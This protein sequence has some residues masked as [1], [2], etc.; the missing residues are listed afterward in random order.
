MRPKVYENHLRNS[1]NEVE[2]EKQTLI[3]IKYILYIAFLLIAAASFGQGDQE[4]KEAKWNTERKKLKYKKEA[5]YKGPVDW[6]GEDIQR[7]AIKI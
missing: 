4:K 7:K 6:Y 2:A 5:E 1:E 3:L